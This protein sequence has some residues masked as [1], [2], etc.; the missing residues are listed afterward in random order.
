MLVMVALSALPVAASAV[1]AVTA[2]AV[3]RRPVVRPVVRDVSPPTTPANVSAS[4]VSTTQIALAWTASSDNIGVTG[5]RLERCQGAGCTAFVEVATAS[6]TEVTDAGL[7]PSS[8]YRY[9]LRA[10]DAGGNLG[11][12][13]EVVQTTTQAVT[14]G[15]ATVAGAVSTPYPTINHLSIEWAITGDSNESGVVE[16]RYR[17][18][19]SA[20][21]QRAMLLRRV[22]AGSN[23]GFS[24]ANRHS[25]S[26]FDLQ[27]GTT[28]E[29]QLT[30]TD[31][32]GGSAQRVVTATTRAVPAP[33]ANAPVRSAT[34][35]TLAAVLAQ[36]QPGDIVELAAGT[37]AGFNVE[38]D[39]SPGRPLV[40]RGTPGAVI[41]GEVGLFF[42]HD[43]F[44]TGL[45]VNGRI[46]FNGSSNISVTRCTINGVTT[47]GREGGIITYLRAENAY[48]ADN[49]VTGTTV[50]RESSL[51]V[52][53][54]NLG[55]GILVTG[56]GH[57]IAHNR[58]RGFRDDIS[59]L[60]DG[61]AVDQY[62]IDVVNNDLGEAGD[63][64][65]EADFCFH[66]C[67]ILRNRITNAF[68]GLSSQPS[69]GGPTY[70]IRNFQYN[71]ILQAFKLNR[72]SIGDVILHNT[73]VKNGD[74]FALNAGVPVRHLY[75]RNNLAI[76]G[77]GGTFN[78]WSSG[79]GRVA[80][81][82]LL[83]TAN[84][85]LDHDAFGSTLG[86]FSGQI[87]TNAFT[88]LAQMRSGTSARN[89][90]QVD[91]DAFAATVAY[92]A[93]PMT[94]YP[95]PDLTPRAG[96]AIV[97]SGLPLPNVNDGAVG[98]RP[99]RGAVERGAPAVVYGPR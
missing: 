29:I 44:L 74:A 45:T 65:I 5:Y 47:A 12:Y 8:I 57:V 94:V 20:S 31:G 50:W 67:R 26:L 3:V 69:L 9:R 14:S 91:L 27:P 92:P 18:L 38:R 23:V 88:S 19:G 32:D 21:W 77:P 54:D 68:V 39:G 36:A 15:F 71:V 87:G 33:M 35:A 64:A 81:A 79:S 98:G 86:T 49:V 62:S 7:Q 48:I 83:D 40:I 70:F 11:T 17:P 10:A 93:A 4:P 52:D 30:L 56:P 24:W 22:P 6:T 42:R 1:D 58:V 2:A 97:D 63:D 51:G 13:S 41:N 25:G 43:V 16:V 95:A 75:M 80:V 53:G 82:T 76:G 28:Y 96:S 59:F 90:V 89:A 99:D 55:E 34:P 73:V 84:S 37:Y 46:R 72:L 60:E 85:S 66:N 78:G 61:E